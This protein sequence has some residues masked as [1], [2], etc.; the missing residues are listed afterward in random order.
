MSSIPWVQNARQTLETVVCQVTRFRCDD[1]YKMIEDR[2]EMFLGVLDIHNSGTGRLLSFLPVQ[3]DHFTPIQLNAVGTDIHTD[4]VSIKNAILGGLIGSQAKFEASQWFDILNAVQVVAYS[5]V[6]D[7]TKLVR[8][9]LMIALSRSDD[10]CLLLTIV[11]DA[12]NIVARNTTSCLFLSWWRSF[13][14]ARM[15]VIVFNLSYLVRFLISEWW[16]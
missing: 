16:L 2:V 14:N 11:S 4:I 12:S 13:C 3:F 8:L 15:F 5:V 9:S 6:P 7:L 10:E 1:V